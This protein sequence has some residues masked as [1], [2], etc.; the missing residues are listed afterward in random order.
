MWTLISADGVEANICGHDPAKR[1]HSLW[2]VHEFILFG[3]V[4]FFPTSASVMTH[5]KCTIICR[6][7]RSW[8][9]IFKVR[10]MPHSEIDF[11]I[12]LMTSC[13]SFL[14]RVTPLFV[15]QL[16]MTFYSLS[17]P[18]LEKECMTRQSDWKVIRA[19]YGTLANE[20]S[21]LLEVLWF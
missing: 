21:L 18:F 8:V 11:F 13:C 4:Q 16:D 14:F 17:R 3:R 7:T 2:R 15:W 12:K 19:H 9:Q 1:D 20:L 6:R 10:A 5:D